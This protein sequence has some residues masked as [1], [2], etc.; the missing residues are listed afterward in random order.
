MAIPARTAPEMCWVEAAP[1]KV[2]MEE[3]VAEAVMLV[4][5]WTPVALE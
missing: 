2:A 1:V 4:D 3:P 5:E